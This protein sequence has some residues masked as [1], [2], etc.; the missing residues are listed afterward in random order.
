M[1]YKDSFF[2]VAQ[3]SLD[4]VDLVASWRD[5]PGKCAEAGWGPR[6]SGGRETLGGGPCFGSGE[7]WGPQGQREDELCSQADPGDGKA[8][9]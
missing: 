5:L 9:I 7:R 2:E 6:E 8:G 3:L 4:S 1:L